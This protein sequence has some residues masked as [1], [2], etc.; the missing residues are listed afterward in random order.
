LKPT[1]LQVSNISL[2]KLQGFEKLKNCFECGVCTASCPIAELIPNIYNP[3]NILE[4][5]FLNPESLMHAEEIWLCAWCYRCYKRCPQNLKIPE[6]LLSLKAQIIEQQSLQGFEKAIK[7]VVKNVPLP[8]ITYYVCF[9]PERAGI[10]GQLIYKKL[11]EIIEKH[12]E[13]ELA[14]KTNVDHHKK[15]AIIGSGPAGL[16]AAYQLI[17]KG[18]LVTIFEAMPQA[19]GM[20]RK[21]IPEYRLPQKILNEEIRHIQNMGVEIKTNTILGKDC[22]FND[23]QRDGYKAVFIAV[24]AHGSRKLGVEG[25]NL[26]GVMDALDFLHKVNCGEEVKLGSK[27]TVIGGGNVAIDAARTALRRGAKEVIILYRRTRGEMPANPW[28][29][30]EAEKEGVKIEFLVGPRKFLGKEGKIA[31]VECVKMQLGV[32][33]ETGRRS[34]I[35]IEG[36]EFQLETDTVILAIGEYPLLDFLPK[37]VKVEVDKDTIYVNPFTME[38]TMQGVFAGGDVVTGPASVIEAIVAGV[39][40]AKSIEEYL[41]KGDAKS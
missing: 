6:L 11:E 15:V 20:L 31:A 41:I 16:T 29:T 18:C 35:P 22:S 33:D 8:M 19:G 32:P 9:H 36:S 25:E 14:A 7:T 24:G 10:N 37:D 34:P 12:R 38:T 3:R 2:K 13:K 23:L 1:A 26:E 28:E 4:R 40:A 27:V 21:C 17:K 5:V 30:T 39:K